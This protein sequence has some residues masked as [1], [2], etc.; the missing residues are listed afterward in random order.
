MICTQ[1]I[2]RRTTGFTIRGIASW[3]I[4]KVEGVNYDHV[5]ILLN[6]FVY[7]AHVKG[8]RMVKLS[9]WQSFPYNREY[10]IKE[11]QMP[12]QLTDQLEEAIHNQL[13]NHT[14]YDYFSLLWVLFYRLTGVWVGLRNQKAKRKLFCSEFVALLAKHPQ[15]WKYGIKDAH[16]EAIK[17]AC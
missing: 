14:P 13:E 8:L 9:K 1:I 6:G 2:F 7:E 15:F 3:L 11:M 5:A 4:R 12:Y 10:E 17:K 16:D